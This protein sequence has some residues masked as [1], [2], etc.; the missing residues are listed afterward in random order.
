MD[1]TKT[2]KMKEFHRIMFFLDM[3]LFSSS[4]PKKVNYMY[5]TAS[6]GP[7]RFMKTTLGALLLF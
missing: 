3:L 7:L 6:L 5:G 2:A 1:F 4:S